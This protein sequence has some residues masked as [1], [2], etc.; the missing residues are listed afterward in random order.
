MAVEARSHGC[1]GKA[2]SHGRRTLL[3]EIRA[4]HHRPCLRNRPERYTKQYDV[5]V[6]MCAYARLCAHAQVD[7]R[8][9][10]RMFWG[11]GGNEPLECGWLDGC[12]LEWLD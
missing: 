12:L 7:A 9:H 8:V 6:C 10:V 2:L 4:V 3:P 5:C 11:W 1:D